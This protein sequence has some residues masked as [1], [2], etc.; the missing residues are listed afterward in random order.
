[1][2]KFDIPRNDWLNDW[3]YRVSHNIIGSLGAGTDYQIKLTAHY[4]NGANSGS[5][6][7]LDGKSKSD[8]S[9]VR[10]TDND[11]ITPLSYW[12]ETKT[13]GDRAV[14][15]VKVNDNLDTN[16][17]IYIYFGNS[18]VSSASSIASTFPFADDFSGVLLDSTKWDAIGLGNISVTD[19]TCVLSAKSG[20][21][22]WA[23]MRGN[24]GFGVNYSIR[25][26]SLIYDQAFYRWTHHGFGDSTPFTTSV[27]EAGS[28]KGMVILNDFADFIS[29]SQETINYTWSYRTKS[30]GNLTRIDMSNNAPTPGELSTFEIQRLGES[31]VAFYQNGNFEGTTT[32]NVPTVNM[33]AMF[34]VDNSGHEQT[35]VTSIDWVIIRKCISQEPSSSVWGGLEEIKGVL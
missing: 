4:Q 12:V 10:F 29:M 17:L 34:A 6:F 25:F 20:A 32:A 9:D 23:Y 21:G 1:M 2:P 33:R 13:N 19:G 11:G 7:Y 14:F 28:D 35:A 15:W 26:S 31:K 8:F 24:V 22:G 30:D 16:Q 5:D 27:A 3:Q 18:K